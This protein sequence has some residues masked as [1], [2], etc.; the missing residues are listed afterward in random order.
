MVPADKT[1][2]MDISSEDKGKLGFERTPLLSGLSGDYLESFMDSLTLKSFSEGS[3]IYAQGEEGEYL[4]LIGMGSVRLEARQSSG[5][6][7][8]YSRL[9]EG[10]CFGEHAFMSRVKRRDFAVADTE[11]SVL[12]IDRDTF[13]RWVKDNPAISG[14]VEQFYRQRVL[15]RVLA[16]TPVFEGVPED[17]KLELAN[18]FNMIRL[19][20]GKIVVREGEQGDSF[21]LIR[22]GI[23]RIV[24]CGMQK[25]GKPIELGRM[26]EGSFFGEVALLTEKPRTATVIAESNVELMELT[27]EKFD[28]IARVHPS[29]RKIVE[30]YQKSRVKETIKVLMNQDK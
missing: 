6:T 3:E 15:A 21:F 18:S 10:D 11:V 9:G 17:A 13:D 28:S 1:M 8:V 5:R 23:V 30:A 7:K 26:G 22:S 14:T 12:M 16:L 20:K 2:G 19:A 29:I 27:R 24:T 4:Y 25:D